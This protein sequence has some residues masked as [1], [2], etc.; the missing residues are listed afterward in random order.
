M[1]EPTKTLVVT[2]EATVDISS[3]QALH[4]HLSEALRNGQTVEIE[5]RDVERIDAAILQTFFGFMKAAAEKG[6]NVRW[7]RTSKA[8]QEA[9]NL[10]GMSKALGIQKG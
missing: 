6:V 10:M 1:S 9:A 7:R 8:L 3:V 2:C 4:Q 5:A